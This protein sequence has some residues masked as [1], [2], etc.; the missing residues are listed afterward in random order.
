MLNPICKDT[1]IYHRGELNYDVIA[2]LIS[3]LKGK[4]KGVNH[5]F[6]IY[7]KL[8]T[9]MIESLENIVR[10]NNYRSLTPELLTK[11]PS[12]FRICLDNDN[13]FV[14]SL[15]VVR[16][17]DTFVLKRKI[18]SLINLEFDEIKE[19]YKRKITDGKFSVRGGA[20]LGIIEMAKIA[21]K[22]IEGTFQKIDQDYSLFHLTMNL[23]N[24]T[25]AAFME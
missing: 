25:S 24:D 5:Q 13:Y 20:G 1:I 18:N 22:R 6:R 3:S 17:E 8:L 21:E 7:K 4:M 10:Y 19:L 15:N 11:Y 16:N 12:E 2:D 23:K 14:E 9:L